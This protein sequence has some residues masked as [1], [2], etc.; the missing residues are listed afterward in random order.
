MLEA[1]FASIFVGLILLGL[2]ALSYGIMFK[3]LMPK[4][5]YDYY[6]IIPSEGCGE[7]ITQAAYSARTKLNLIGD[8]NHGKVLVL[9]KG[10]N[11]AQRL[12]CLNV[13][14]QTNGIYL[15]SVEELEELFK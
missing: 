11:E 10:M 7:K 6:I 2:L 14:R 15:V 9:D 5:K 4:G 8:E 12:S 1:F 13:C 3:L